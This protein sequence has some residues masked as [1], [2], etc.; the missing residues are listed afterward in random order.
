MQ[1]GAMGSFQR[2]ERRACLGGEVSRRF[3]VRPSGASRRWGVE[4]ESWEFDGS[5]ADYWARQ[6]ADDAVKPTR[7]DVAWDFECGEDEL[8]C[9]AAQIV[10]DHAE[11]IGVTLGVSGQG[12]YLTRYVGAACSPLRLRIYRKDIQSPQLVR[13]G[14]CGP[15]MRFESI[16]RDQQAARF[17]AA[18]VR[19]PESAF[20]G[21]AS[22][23]QRLTGLCLQEGREELPAFVEPEAVEPAGELFRFMQQYAGTIQA[24]ADQGISIESAAEEFSRAAGRHRATD[25]RTRRRADRIRSSG[26]GADVWRMFLAMVRGPAGAGSTLPT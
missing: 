3:D 17:W 2:G 7:I 25:W 24:W 26:G 10:W 22:E 13:L 15:L 16:H 6:L 20:A 14:L 8:A 23:V 12:H 5:H 21:A 9:H 11:S 19:D 4:Y 18:W 1:F